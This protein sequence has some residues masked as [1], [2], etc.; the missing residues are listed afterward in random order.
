PVGYHVFVGFV[1]PD[2]LPPRS[3]PNTVTGRI[4]NLHIPRLPEL[5]QWDSNSYASL[6]HTNAWVGLNSAG[7]LGGVIAVAQ[8]APDGSF[9]IS[10]VP[11]G[12]YQLVVWDEYLD[13]I[14][15]FRNLQVPGG[16]NVGNFPVF[17]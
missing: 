13:Q 17:N 15:G 3:G 16:N 5:T 11:N 14:I 8:A 10:N 12:S 6:S 4:T 1:S 9:S 2:R 7:G